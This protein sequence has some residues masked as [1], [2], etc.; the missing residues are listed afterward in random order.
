MSRGMRMPAFVVT[1]S[2]STPSCERERLAHVPDTD[3]AAGADEESAAT[4]PKKGV[5]EQLANAVEAAV[6]IVIEAA[7]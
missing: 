3:S 5:A 1:H 4:A 2:E 6:D 7:L